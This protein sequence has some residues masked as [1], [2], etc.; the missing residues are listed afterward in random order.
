[1]L[2]EAALLHCPI[3][4]ALKVTQRASDCLTFTEEKQRIDAIRYLLHRNYP[5]ENFGVETTL[6]RIGH[7]GRNSFR[8]DF[9]VYDTAFDDMKVCQS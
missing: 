4:G 7:K 2:S 5:I 1:M 6:F 8:T 9:A 3:R